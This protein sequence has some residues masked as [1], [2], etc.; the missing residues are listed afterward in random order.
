MNIEYNYDIIRQYIEDEFERFDDDVLYQFDLD[1][2]LE[3]GELH[4]ELFNTCY[5]VVNRK[6]A[7]EWFDGDLESYIKVQRDVR[8]TYESRYGRIRIDI[9]DPM[10]VVNQYVYFVGEE[11]LPE[12]LNQ[13]YKDEMTKLLDKK[14]VNN[15]PKLIDRIWYFLSFFTPE[16]DTESESEDSSVSTIESDTESSSEIE[17]SSEYNSND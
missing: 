5:Y 9:T 12:M 3:W 16:S 1:G 15:E 13:R 6:Q 11:L 8:N 2:E 17:E 10:K 4:E 7:V 14:L